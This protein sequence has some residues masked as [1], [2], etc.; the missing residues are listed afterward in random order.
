MHL[1]YPKLRRLKQ[2]SF[3][4]D[5]FFGICRKEKV[6]EGY[7]YDSENLSGDKF[8]VFSVKNPD[9]MWTG[10]T[11][12]SLTEKIYCDGRLAVGG[13]GITAAKN[14]GD[15]FCYCTDS[16]VF[17]NGKRL[18]DATL[19]KDV[20]LRT[21]VP[22]GRNIFIAPDGEYI[23]ETAAGF[24]VI[25]TCTC[26]TSETAAFSFCDKDG[27]EVEA[28]YEYDKP[29]FPEAGDRYISEDE[30]SMTL[31][32]YSEENMW[33]DAGS[34]YAKIT[35]PGIGSMFLAGDRIYVSDAF[36]DRGE[37]KVKKIIDMNT[38]V[39]SGILYGEIAEFRN[40]TAQKKIP[41]TD[42]AIEHNNRIWGCRYGKNNNGDFV[43]E[44]YASSLGDPTSWETFE[45][46]STD[47]YQVSL[48]CPGE[49]TG[50]KVLGGDILFFKEEYIIRISGESPSDFS[51][52]TFPARGVQR[53]CHN[54]IVNIN[55]QLFYKSRYGVMRYDGTFPV[56]ISDNLGNVRYSDAVAEGIDNKY[57]IAMTDDTGGRSIFV[58]HLNTSQWYKEDDKKNTRF[59]VRIR[60]CLYYVC[61]GQETEAEKYY[62]FRLWD[63]SMISQAVSILSPHENSVFSYIPSERVCWYAQSGKTG[64][65]YLPSRQILRRIHITMSLDEG[66]EVSMYIKSDNSSEWQ[67]LCSIDTPVS[68]VFTVPVSTPPCHSYTLKLEGRGQCRIMNIVR[69]TEINQEVRN[70]G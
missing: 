63:A 1:I 44:I 47:S 22:F 29:D 42:F 31:Y 67:R 36:F 58:F 17:I 56:E 33:E 2:K 23:R 54:S 4:N 7:F 48:G 50:A 52:T 28:G 64:D 70:I 37:C 25:H 9:A 65:D 51:V 15:K 49:F 40:F 38:V 43:N 30:G 53:G 3:R 12:N 16:H 18:I 20:S 8:P 69:Q 32:K 62:S 24:E 39:V 6:S 14:V 34:L 13:K 46:I 66:A 60:N 68:K 35:S 57:Y 11:E 26:H 27:N 21:I 19:H 61:L 55:E 41:L 45:G 59:M 10:E 5:G